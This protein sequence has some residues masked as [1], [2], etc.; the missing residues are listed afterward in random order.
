MKKKSRDDFDKILIEFEDDAEF[1]K[2][3]KEFEKDDSKH[4][5]IAT[6]SAILRKSYWDEFVLGFFFP[7]SSFS[8][9]PV[10]AA[11]ADELDLTGKAFIKHREKLE[12]QRQLKDEVKQTALAK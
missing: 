9:F 4:V 5:S 3:L 2:F 11:R 10:A 7:L 1:K 12:S 6:I 8:Y